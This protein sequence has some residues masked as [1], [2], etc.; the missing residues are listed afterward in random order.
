[1]R[2][3]RIA[4]LEALGEDRRL[5]LLGD[6]HGL[7]CR[8]RGRELLD[9]L[10]REQ[11]VAGRDEDGLDAAVVAEKRLL[12]EGPAGSEIF[13]RGED[14]EGVA[15]AE[16][17]VAVAEAPEILAEVMEPPLGVG[18]FTTAGEFEE[19]SPNDAV[20]VLGGAVGKTRHEARDPE[21][22]EEML[23]VHIVDGKHGRALQQV[24]R[25][26]GLEAERFERDALRRVGLFGVSR[27]REEKGKDQDKHT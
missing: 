19:Y 16:E 3:I 2:G 21:G 13:E 27:E 25:R 24:T 1:L 7:D 22:D 18:E 17:K 9:G 5:V 11:V 23:R 10:D 14:G 20:F 8:G 15:V 6:G 12:G 4:A 26:D